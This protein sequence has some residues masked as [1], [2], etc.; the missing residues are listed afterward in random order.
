MS[1]VARHWK[2]TMTNWEHHRSRFSCKKLPKNSMSTILQS[3]GIW[4][5]LERRKSSIS[6]CLMSWPQIK[7]IV[8]LKCYLLLF[9]TATRNHCSTGLWCETK[10]GYYK[11][12]GKDQLSGCTEEKFQ[13]TSQSLT[14]TYNGHG[15]YWMVCWLSDPPQLSESQWNHCIEKCAQEIDTMHQKLQCLQ[16]ALVNRKGPILLPGNAWLRIAQPKLQKLNKLG[17]KVLP[18]PPYPPDLLLT[19][20]HFFKHFDNF[21]QECFHSQQEAENA[22]QEFMQSQSR[23]IYATGINK[24]IYHW[25]KC[26]DCNGPYFH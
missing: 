4:S 25:Q 10:N 23:N 1:A 11:P 17:Y 7:R 8:I 14:C 2:L 18:H 26:V 20:S 13:S 19:D 22:F 6:G 21:L 12:T 16:P 3:L 5:K 9:Y 24:L 15:H